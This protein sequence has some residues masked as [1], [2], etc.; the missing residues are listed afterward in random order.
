MHKMGREAGSRSTVCYGTGMCQA[1]TVHGQCWLRPHR[2][3]VLADGHELRLAL[4]LQRALGAQLAGA[5][6][7]ARADG[8]LGAV[9]P[10]Q[11]DKR[12]GVEGRGG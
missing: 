8:T 12:R 4:V 3:E 5:V 6:Q 10:S 2:Q 9:M 11:A 1:H 7:P